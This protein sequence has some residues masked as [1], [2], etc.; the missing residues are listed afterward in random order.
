MV[1]DNA[2]PAGQH[3]VTQNT[4]VKTGPAGPDVMEPLELLIL[5][6]SDP[7]G[8]NTDVEMG[9]A[10]PAIMEPLELLVLDRADPAGQHAVI[11]DTTRWLEHPLAR[12]ES[13]LCDGL[14]E[15]ISDGEPAACEVPDITLDSRPMEGIPYLEHLAPGGRWTVDPWRGLC[16]WNHW[17][18]RFFIHSG[19]CN[20]RNVL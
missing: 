18:S 2:D 8:Q 17:R 3:S 19:L 6:R 11:R 5:D 7:D 16:I 15:K 1:H 4:V 10:G 13:S 12:P 9:L 20:V 14:V